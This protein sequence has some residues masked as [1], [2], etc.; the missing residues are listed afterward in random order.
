MWSG[1]RKPGISRI[2]KNGC[3]QDKSTDLYETEECGVLMVRAS[4]FPLLTKT[5]RRKYIDRLQRVLM[6]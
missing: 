2:E 6:A 5:I 3:N 1:F 4:Y